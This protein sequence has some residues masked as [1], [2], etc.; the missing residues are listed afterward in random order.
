MI[1]AGRQGVGP[2]GLRKLVVFVDPGTPDRI[3]ETARADGKLSG[4]AE[5]PTPHR[6]MPA[7]PAGAD[8]ASRLNAYPKGSPAPQVLAW[9]RGGK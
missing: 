4:G 1:S 2:P 8:W 7:E 3:A 9:P 5:T 6:C